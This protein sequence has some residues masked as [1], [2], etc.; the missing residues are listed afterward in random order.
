MR[1]AMPEAA[2][3]AD[4]A[5]EAFIAQAYESGWTVVSQSGPVIKCFGP[6]SGRFYEV[7]L[8]HGV[9]DIRARVT[10]SYT[11]RTFA[12]IEFYQGGATL[13]YAD[14][15]AALAALRGEPLSEAD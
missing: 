5:Y 4:V 2:D 15:G 10:F 12:G 3:S 6:S 7:H 11:A 14:A 9:V 8:A 13:H 1:R